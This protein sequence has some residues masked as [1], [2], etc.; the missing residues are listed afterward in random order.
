MYVGKVVL[1][2]QNLRPGASKRAA[3][4]GFRHMLNRIEAQR[5]LSPTYD[6]GQEMA[7]HQRLT[8]ATWGTLYFADSHSHWRRLRINE[9]TNGLLRQ[10]LPKGRNL[11]G[12]TQEERKRLLGNCR[13]DHASRWA[14]SVPRSCSPRTCSI[15]GSIMLPFALGY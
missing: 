9:N 11:S 2:N 10:Y 8:E 14:T 3:L 15:S 6:Q 5:C 1:R 7:A 13:P 12:F 4:S